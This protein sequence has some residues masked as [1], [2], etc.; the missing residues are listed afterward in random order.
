MTTSPA[1]PPIDGG[2]SASLPPAD[3]PLASPARRAEL[4]LAGYFLFLLAWL[5]AIALVGAGVRLTGSGMSIPDWPIIYYGPDGTK[6][7][8]L[9]PFTQ[10][11]WETVLLTY[12]EQYLWPRAAMP[13][14]VLMPMGQFQREFLTEYAH[15]A[16]VKVFGLLY[17]AAVAF[18]LWKPRLRRKVAPLLIGAGLVLVAQIVLGGA[19]VR[20][21]TPQLLVA[22][23]LSTAV[24]FISM[25]VYATLKLLRRPEDA[26]P[27]SVPRLAV[28]VWMVLGVAL[29]QFFTGGVMAKTQ[30]ARVQQLATWP[31]MGEQ[32]VPPAEVLWDDL[33]SPPIANLVEN[34]WLIQFVHRW[35]AFA[36][37]GAV[38]WMAMRLVGKPLSAS[39]RWALR[40]AVFVLALQVLLGILTLLH[41]VPISL[42]LA[43]L[44]TGLVLFLLLVV[45]LY[46]VRTSSAIHLLEQEA[47]AAAEHRLEAKPA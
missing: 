31:M 9:P 36:L 29:I 45:L 8:I 5:F 23:H 3:S 10:S 25:V 1:A 40:G 22:F 12:H 32:L 47:L 4:R 7:S 2:A 15:R 21:H 35:W 42:G 33:I 11:G 18:A 14:G 28:V 13:E 46:E 41:M 24:V 43:H 37:V 16:L 20:K 34:V 30:A 27:P 38:L 44:G 17:L 19:V 39:G 26:L 6:G